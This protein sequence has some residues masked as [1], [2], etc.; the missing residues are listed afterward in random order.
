MVLLQ[1]CLIFASQEY[2]PKTILNF[3]GISADTKTTI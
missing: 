3:L 2:N 1:I